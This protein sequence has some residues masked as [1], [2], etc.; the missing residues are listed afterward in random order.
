MIIY[1][2]GDFNCCYY[3]AFI[4]FPTFGLNLFYINSGIANFLLV[5]VY[6]ADFFQPF[7]FNLSGWIS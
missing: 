6:V 4:F 1:L 2:P 3:F 5:N 7:T